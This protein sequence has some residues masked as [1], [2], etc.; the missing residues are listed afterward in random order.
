M[1]DQGLEDGRSEGH[2]QG[3]GVEWHCTSL[4]GGTVDQDTWL[5]KP[6][7]REGKKIA[8]DNNSKEG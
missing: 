5:E 7:I 1:R 8:G 4:E 6:S 2:T 3:K